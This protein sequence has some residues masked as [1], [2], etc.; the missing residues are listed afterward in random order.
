MRMTGKDAVSWAFQPRRF[1]FDQRYRAFF[2]DY[3]M[4]PLHMQVR[5]PT[6]DLPLLPQPHPSPL[7]VAWCRSCTRR[8]FA[9]HRW[10]RFVKCA[11]CPVLP[12]L[13]SMPIWR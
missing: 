3:D 7:P 13:L 11:C 10:H 5:Y 8:A 9:A 6:M 12:T 4:V 1:T 2:T